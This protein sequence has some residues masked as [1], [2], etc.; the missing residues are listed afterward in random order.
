MISKLID[1]IRNLFRSNPS[2]QNLAYIERVFDVR[3]RDTQLVDLVGVHRSAARGGN[4]ERLEFLGDAV[5]DLIISKHLYEQRPEA[6]EGH[7]TRLRSKLVNRTFLTDLALELR[8]HE[9]FA[10]E[11]QKDLATELIVGN[12]FEALVG[13]I[14]LDQGYDVIRSRIL[15]LLEG[16]V[17]LEH[18]EESLNDPKS[19][20]LQWS[21]L[22]RKKVEFRSED[23]GSTEELRFRST[24]LLDGAEIAIGW[25]RNK[26]NAEMD[27]ARSFLDKV[28][29]EVKDS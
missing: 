13:A 6:D 11:K 14:Y 19:R 9:E 21:Q 8:M 25:G 23:V 28:D 2:E 12:A 18:L 24:L 5:L 26:K 10:F 4:N 3:I 16:R 7:L 22:E 15:R 27:A 29:I 17:D 20:L 1:R